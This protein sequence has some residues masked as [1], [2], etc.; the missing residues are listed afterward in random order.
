[1]SSGKIIGASSLPANRKGKNNGVW[2]T[3]DVYSAVLKN[4]WNTSVVS[5]G[6]TLHLD[7]SNPSS[8]PGSGTTWYDLSPSGLN[9][10][11]DASFISLNN[12]LRSGS[13]WSS[14]STS[15][16]NTDTHSLF[17][18]IKFNSTT[19]NT[20]SWSGS[21][22]KMFGYNPAGS[23]RSPGIWRYPSERK[24]HWRYDTANSSADLAETL[25]ADSGGT[26]FAMDVW[27]Y[28][29]VVKN[30]ATAT[31]YVNG[32]S[33]GSQT[34]TNPKAAGNSPIYL[35]EYYTASLASMD[36]IKVYNRALSSSEVAQNYKASQ[37][38][39]P[40]IPAGYLVVG[41][42][43]GGGMDMG[44]G[45]GAGGYLSGNTTFNFDT[46]YSVS[47]GTGGDGAP[48]AG[49]NNQN[50]AHMYNIPA[51]NGRPSSLSGSGVS[52]F[53]L[54]G[55]FGG[56][57][58]RGYSPGIQGGAGG[59][60]GGASGY[61][62]NAGTFLGGLG[63]SGQGNRGGNSTAAYYSG[64]GGGAG[65]Q[66]VDSTTQAD[67]GVGIQNS[68]L[69]TNYYWA[70][71]GGGAG[72]SIEGGNG[73]AG[74]G[75]AGG[76]GTYTGGS[77]LNTGSDTSG[78][79]TNSW[80]NV[81]GGNGGANTGGGGGGGSHYNSNN[82]GGNGGS[83]IVIIRYPDYYPDLLNI[84]TLTYSRSVVAG[85]K[86]YSFTQGSGTFT[87]GSSSFQTPLVEYLIVGGGGG[88]VSGGGGGGGVVLGSMY[89]PISSSITIGA[90]GAGGVANGGSGKSNG[91]DTSF[92]GITALG[93]GHGG[94]N[95]V[96]NGSNSGGNG[97]GG[98]ATS[99]VMTAG[100]AGIQG[101]DST[102]RP[103]G[104]RGRISGILGKPFYFGVIQTCEIDLSS[105]FCLTRIAIRLVK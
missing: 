8:Y 97:G 45:G 34:V 86:I 83:G 27:Y 46:T 69:G 32:T 3:Q 50:T 90:G 81:P 76:T 6:L 99:T 93:G 65:A 87:T 88:G 55:G 91:S 77:G 10:T 4:Y 2:N 63:T 48:A 101:V 35:F 33:I 95:D 9:F 82:K 67:G 80:A 51:K 44:G 37:S 49:T 54:G 43:G 28:V 18:N 103:D 16:L 53:A 60:G 13:T 98:G 21:W 92:A 94:N 11:G 62:D 52:V 47:V 26:Q 20:Q 31:M 100:G 29:G 57:S 7:S 22:E 104:G 66:G 73:G 12:G 59:S 15:I 42:G 75:G 19:T 74:G 79:G 56:S 24:I 39:L 78:G 85:H 38:R 5:N 64:G 84:T 58:Y 23:D 14:A 1:M 40:S 61:N 105:V 70:G 30:G 102:N 71:G 41:G 17:F 89:P 25:P 68:I 36:F 96:L 72:Y